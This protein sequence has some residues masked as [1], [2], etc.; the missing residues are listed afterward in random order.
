MSVIFF[1]IQSCRNVRDRPQWKIVPK[2]HYTSLNMSHW[3]EILSLGAFLQLKFIHS[4]KATKFFKFSTLLL[5]YVVLVKSKVEISQ[6]FVAFSE[7]MN[8]KFNFR[9]TLTTLCSSWRQRSGLLFWAFY[10]ELT[11]VLMECTQVNCNVFA[12]ILLNVLLREKKNTQKW[13]RSGVIII[14]WVK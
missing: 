14:L 2:C 4:E 13:N 1:R 8:F 9:K 12:N 3:I 5:S 10:S 7:Y 6:N 11:L